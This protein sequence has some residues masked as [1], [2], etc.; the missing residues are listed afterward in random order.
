MLFSRVVSC[1]V[2][3]HTLTAAPIN[4][5]TEYFDKDIDNWKKDYKLKKQHCRAWGIKIIGNFPALCSG[6]EHPELFIPT[7][8]F[9]Y[10]TL[11]SLRCFD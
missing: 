1:A 8:C 5:I 10:I 7:I 11:C 2:E 6:L 4:V 3:F 9:K